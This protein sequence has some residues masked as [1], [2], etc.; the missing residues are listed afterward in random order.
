[1][2]DTRP[3][4][5]FDNQGICQACHN[6]D[7]H[8]QTDWGE[9]WRELELLCE[10]H[11]GDGK[12]YDCLIPVSG[13]KDSHFL[14]K[15]LK[16]DMGM[17]PLLFTVTDPFTKTNAGAHNIKNLI[18]RFGCDHFAFTLN[19]DLHRQ[20]IR[21]DFEENLHPL[22]ILE[23][24]IYIVPTMF[25][26]NLGIPLVFYGENS[27]FL[28]G[29]SPDDIPDALPSIRAMYDVLR[30]DFWGKNPSDD[31]IPDSIS[32]TMKEQLEKRPIANMKIGEALRRHLRMLESQTL[33]EVYYMSYYAPWDDEEHY[34]LAKQ[35]DFQDLEGEWIREGWLENY[36]QIDSYGY[37]VHIWCKYPK[38]GF[39]R[40]TDMMSRWIRKGGISRDKALE[41]M[42]PAHLGG[43][44]NNFK[45]H[46]LDPTALEDFCNF[47]GYSKERFWA[48]V[49]RHYN[50]DIFEE[51]PEGWQLKEK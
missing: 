43:D 20:I 44:I 16:E 19:T 35:Y 48:I 13:G 51:R 1:M 31:V 26:A 49:D 42:R 40:V 24:L 23:M 10:K 50:R 11:R 6:Y 38:F 2:P 25:A 8:Q 17:T 5:I 15:T 46:L 41:I 29:T 39:Q 33:P 18:E 30:T 28:Y 22:R 7:K 9:R 27:S 3:G 14:V 47:C 36:T 32:P 45:D 37:L 34:E 4:S 12:I 21:K